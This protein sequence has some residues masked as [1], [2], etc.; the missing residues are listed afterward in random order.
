MI[1]LI[2][3]AAGILFASQAVAEMTISKGQMRAVYEGEG[4]HRLACFDVKN[5]S[6]QNASMMI[7]THTEKT[8]KGKKEVAR[9]FGGTVSSG[10]CIQVNGYDRVV[11]EGAAV[12]ELVS[13]RVGRS[14]L[15]LKKMEDALGRKGS[16]SE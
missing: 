9:T 1:R 4:Q 7:M 8:V 10:K 5:S 15:A 6:G 13:V 14:R 2:L 16:S 3:G 11:I 12:A